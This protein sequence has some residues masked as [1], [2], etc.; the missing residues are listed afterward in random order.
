[1]RALAGHS[2]R[3]ALADPATRVVL[4]RRVLDADDPRS[5][6]DGLRVVD[7]DDGARWAGLADSPEHPD[8]G[9]AWRATSRFDG[10]EPMEDNRPQVDIALQAHDTDAGVPLVIYGEPLRVTLRTHPSVRRAVLH[11]MRNGSSEPLAV[12]LTSGRR[13]F[14]YSPPEP[15]D[16]RILSAGSVAVSGDTQFRVARR[17]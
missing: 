9:P 7:V 17:I 4:Y 5:E 13:A 14:D 15:G 1:M 10:I 2:R 11:F 6:I 8:G 12:V 3:V 16:Y